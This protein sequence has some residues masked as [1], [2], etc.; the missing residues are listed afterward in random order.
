M[1]RSLTAWVLVA[2]LFAGGC[3]MEHKE[4][5]VVSYFGTEK[6]PLQEAP[7]KGQY[8]LYKLPQGGNYVVIFRGPID[9]PA[10]VGFQKAED[11]T[12]DAVAGPTNIPLE[13]GY[14]T[15]KG[16]PDKGQFDAKHTAVQTGTVVLVVVIG[17]VLIA[18][19]ALSF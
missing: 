15:W 6:V 3:T 7:F 1:I 10:K 12:L 18:A 8:V 9:P 11:G 4:R 19:A 16:T 13:A 17:A 5:M 2:A 14:Y